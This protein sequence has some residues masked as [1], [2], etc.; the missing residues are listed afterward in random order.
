MDKRLQK[1]DLIKLNKDVT[2]WEE[3]LS[4]WEREVDSL[5]YLLDKH[6][7]IHEIDSLK[8]AAE[9][10]GILE[11]WTKAYKKLKKERALDYYSMAFE[12]TSHLEEKIDEMQEKRDKKEE[13]YDLQQNKERKK[14]E[15]EDDI[16]KKTNEIKAL[17][18]QLS[19]LI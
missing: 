19:L 14:K 13:E 15:L 7:E 5:R 16:Q 11:M 6:P 12:V 2:E 3:K 10:V 8:W 1:D 4:A 9:R 17:K 18:E